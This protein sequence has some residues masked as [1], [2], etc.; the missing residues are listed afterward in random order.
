M[1]EIQLAD[2]KLLKATRIAG[3]EKADLALLKCEELDCAVRSPAFTETVPRGT[4]V[5][6]LGY[7]EMTTL[8]ASLKA[9]RG[10]ISAV[11][12]AERRRSLLVR[13]R[14]ERR[15]QRRA[16]LRRRG[17]VVAVHYLGINTASRYGGGIPEFRRPWISCNR[18]CPI[19]SRACR[20]RRSCEWPQVDEKVRSIDRA[21]L[22][23]QEKW[24]ARYR[25]PLGPT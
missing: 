23:P 25:R 12:D 14:D 13:R 16:R 1:F 22:G 7:P 2:G 5:M 9:T 4:D 24:K 3:R 11:P 6:L 15:Q 8:G 17:N 20:T 19:S 10:S 18:R 21:H